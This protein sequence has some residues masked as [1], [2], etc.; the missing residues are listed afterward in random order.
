MRSASL[1]TRHTLAR[2][3]LS[4]LCLAVAGLTGVAACSDPFALTASSEVNT[5]T[6]AVF[7]ITGTPLGFPAALNTTLRTL[8]RV[9]P[10]FDFDIAF[11]IDTQ[12]H[13]VLIPVR[14][15]GGTAT[16]TRQ[17]GLQKLAVPFDEMTLAPTTGYVYDSTRV[18]NDGEA[19]VIQAQSDQCTLFASTFLYSKLAID[20]VNVARREI[21]F[22]LVHDPDCSFR[23]LA[24]GIP[25]R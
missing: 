21:F 22:R 3:R 20:S 25:T 16:S 18:L 8:V 4:L 2:A 11:D 9:D 10:T 13:T 17:V 23:S 14:L 1:V 15:V 7:A 6:L 19:V 12:G 5:D 24:P